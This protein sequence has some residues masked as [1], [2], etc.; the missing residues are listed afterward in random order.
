[1]N[2]K[3]VVIAT[4]AVSATLLATAGAAL[5]FTAPVAGELFYEG[6]DFASKLC[7]GGPAATIGLGGVASA[8]FFLFKQQVLPA[9]GCAMAAIV[10]ANS[11]KITQAMGFLF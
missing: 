1:M 4:L 7:S 11:V 5:A 8:G 3:K 10:I 6:Y 2:K 9:A